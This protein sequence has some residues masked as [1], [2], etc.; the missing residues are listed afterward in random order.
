MS[1]GTPTRSLFR[2]AKKRF[3]GASEADLHE[4]VLLQVKTALKH[5]SNTTPDADIYKAADAAFDKAADEGEQWA[6]SLRNSLRDNTVKPLLKDARDKGLDPV[7]V[8]IY[9]T[10]L[11]KADVEAMIAE[12]DA[13]D[14]TGDSEGDA[15]PETE[16]DGDTNGMSTAAQYATAGH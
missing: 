7:T 10:G 1:L 6:V 12:L 4:F 13:E 16:T 9:E 11:G 15:Q 8:V 3:P 14:A 5:P 2:A